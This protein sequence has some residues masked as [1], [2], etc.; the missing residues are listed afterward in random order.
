MTRKA[1][2]SQIRLLKKDEII[3]ATWLNEVASVA[4]SAL[5]NAQSSE[6]QIDNTADGQ[7]QENPLI[8]TETSRTTTTV[9]IEDDTDPTVFVDIERIDDVTF[10]NSSGQTL[11][12]TFNWPP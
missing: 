6:T 11:K 10:S 9:R 4:G 5:L 7:D 3:R 12:L 2:G 8:F 1:R